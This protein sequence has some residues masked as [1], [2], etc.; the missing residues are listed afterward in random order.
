MVFDKHLELEGLHAF[1]SPSQFHWINYTQDK[2]VERWANAQATEMGT[3]LHAFAH[4]AIEL[5]RMQPRNHD[6][7]NLFINDAIGYKMI[8]EQPLFYSWNCF[9]TADAI[10][11]KRNF[12]RIH[13]LKTGKT[14]AHFEQLRVYAALFCLNY[15]NRVSELRREG[16][17]DGDIARLLDVSLKELH[18][19]PE[20]MNGIEL[21]IY[22]LGD[23][24]VEEADPTEIRRLMD[25]IVS[26]DNIIRNVK[27]EE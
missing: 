1:L 2:L 6:T 9:G 19:D 20:Q 17:S 23:I 14:E 5:N 12:L 13:D 8:S 18:F 21:R 3:K 24:R 16:K 15:Q 7:V 4:E 27:A 11:Y 26:F 25:I 22:Q 10:S